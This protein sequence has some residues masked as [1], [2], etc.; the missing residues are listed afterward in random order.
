VIWIPNDSLQDGDVPPLAAH[1]RDVIAENCAGM[2][3][4]DDLQIQELAQAVATYVSDSSGSG[5]Y[6]DSGYLVMLASRALFSI[7]E[8]KAA[9]RVLV[10]GTGLV[11]PSEWS[12]YGGKSIWTL[13]L[14]RMTVRDGATLE[15][16]FFNSLNIILDCVAEA[17]D[18]TDGQG[19]LGLRHAGTAAAEILRHGR[20]RKQVAFT[21]EIA[22]ACRAKL[23]QIGRLRRWSS[24]PEL[25][26]IDLDAS[27]AGTAGA[28]DCAR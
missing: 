19:A 5:M 1:V 9:H 17:W 10:F 16:V 11:H 21:E 13:D 28:L 3:N 23:K 8:R 4:L 7:G 27:L 2:P 22:D 26:M 6:V 18:P 14:G 15:L 12:F 25:L 20:G 24:T